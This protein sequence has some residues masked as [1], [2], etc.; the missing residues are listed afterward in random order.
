MSS[1]DSRIQSKFVQACSRFWQNTKNGRRVDATPVQVNIKNFLNPIKWC[2][3]YW[4]CFKE[5]PGICV[6]ALVLQ[7]LLC[8]VC[9]HLIVLFMR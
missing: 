6:L 4:K 5:S 1:R 3:F 9:V 7:F 2:Q 8:Q